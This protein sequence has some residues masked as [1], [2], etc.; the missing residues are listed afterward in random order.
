[1]KNI[2]VEVTISCDIDIEVA[3]E[4]WRA[5]NED[6]NREDRVLWG[7]L[8]ATLGGAQELLMTYISDEGINDIA[9]DGEVLV[10]WVLE[11]GHVES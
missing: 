10:E 2:S 7:D 6:Q 9:V 5:F 8:K 1:M 11:Y 3:K 4:T